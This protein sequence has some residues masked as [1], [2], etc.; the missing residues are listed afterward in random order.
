MEYCLQPA[1]SGRG[2]PAAL[3]VGRRGRLHLSGRSDEAA[4][5]G[6]IGDDGNAVAVDAHGAG[7]ADVH[8]AVAVFQGGGDWGGG[9]AAP[10]HGVF[11]G[12]MGNWARR[13]L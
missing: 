4:R 10:G 2:G 7:R 13:V 11:K 5:E 6:I 12:K 9:A 3:S 1:S 8:G